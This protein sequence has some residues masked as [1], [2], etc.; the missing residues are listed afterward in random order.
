MSDEE[1]TT[2]PRPRT[3]PIV[4]AVAGVVVLLVAG[5]IIWAA[6]AG[7]GGEAAGPSASA[8]VAIPS[9][10]PGTAGGATPG[11]TEEPPPADV[12]VP[13]EL[14]PIPPDEEAVGEDGVRVK[15]ERIESVE[16]EAVSAGELSG[17]AIRVTIAVTNG[18]DQPLDLGFTVANAYAGPDRIP[19]GTV[20]LPGS[21]PFE[22]VLQPGET[23]T[24]VRIFTIPIDERGDVTITVDYGAS[25]PTVVFS[26]AVG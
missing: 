25:V 18:S 7:G 2:R 3:W 6:I 22:G 20:T 23:G 14:D 13:E 26:G 15:L 9:P 21:V 11:A 24:G 4:A 8:T 17:P 5:G 12:P 16:G 10:S 1:D 19:A